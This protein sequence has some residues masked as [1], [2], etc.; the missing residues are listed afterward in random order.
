MQTAFADDGTWV[1]RE[2]VGTGV[3]NWADWS[4][5][6]NWEGG[7][8]PD[9]T[10]VI[11]AELPASQVYIRATQDVALVNFKSAGTK[12]EDYPVVLSDKTIAIR[13]AA[14]TTVLLSGLHFYAPY[15]WTTTSV[16]I[17]PNNISLCGDLAAKSGAL[18]FG[19]RVDFRLDRYANSSSP[20]RTNE[21][22]PS[23]QDMRMEGSAKL[24]FYCPRGS[25]EDETSRWSQAAGSPFLTRAAGQDE[26]SLSVGTI[27]TGEGVPED[28][29]LKRILPDGSIE[30]SAAVTET[31]ED[32]ELT[33]AAFAP[34]VTYAMNRLGAYNGAGV[35]ELYV[36][37][38]RAEDEFTVNLGLLQ[39]VSGTV[40]NCGRMKI[41]TDAGFLPG[42]IVFH[43]N[44]DSE[45]WYYLVS[46]C[47]LQIN[48]TSTASGCKGCR[49]FVDDATTTARISVAAGVSA[50]SG[51]LCSLAGTLVKDDDGEL[52]VGFTNVYTGAMVVEAG[53][54]TPKIL[55]AGEAGHLSSLTV[56]AN[57]TFTVPTEGFLCDTPA[58][59]AG[60]R[61]R[62]P[63]V[64]FCGDVSDAAF[65][66]VDV[67]DC[68]LCD[69]NTGA[70][71]VRGGTYAP[72]SADGQPI[73]Y[74]SLL[75]KAG[76]T[77]VVPAEG[78]SCAVLTLEPGATLVGPGVLLYES[79][80]EED[81]SEVSIGC[82]G[83]RN[84]NG[85]GTDALSLS[86]VSGDSSIWAEDGDTIL[87]FRTNA[88]VKVAG[89]GVVDVLL[90][91]GGGGGGAYGGGGGGGGGVVY[92]QRFEVVDGYYGVTVGR[93]GLGSTASNKPGE[94]GFDSSC[95]GLVAFGGGGGGTVSA[96][97]DGGCGGGAGAKG[98]VTAGTL[99]G[100][101]G[102]EGQGFAGGAS[103]T[104]STSHW[105]SLGGGGGGAGTP[106]QTA[107][108]EENPG[109][110][111]NGGDGI[112][113]TICKTETY[114]GGGGG[115][116]GLSGSGYVSRG[117]AGGG[118]AG[119]GNSS[120]KTQVGL[121]GTDGLG[122]GGGGGGRYVQNWSAGGN[123]GSGIVIIRFRREIDEKLLPLKPIAEGGQIRRRKGYAFHTFST[124]GFFTV[125]QDVYVDVLAVGGG[126]GG[127]T[128]AGG[129]GGGGGVTVVSNLLLRAGTY[130]VEVGLGGKGATNR[131]F[132]AKDGGLS[133]LFTGATNY[134][135]VA[136]GGGGGGS[137]GFAGGTGANGGGAGGAYPYHGA[138]WRDG[139]KALSDEGFGG[140]ASTNCAS[141]TYGW[142]WCFGG[143]GGG[144]GAVGVT[145]EFEVNEATSTLAWKIPGDGG[146]GVC[147]DFTG[148]STWY[149]GGGGGAGN[150]GM[151][152]TSQDFSKGG[153]GGGGIGR[154]TYAGYCFPG[155]D[156]EDGLGGGG[157]G[158]SGLGDAF[159][160]SGASTDKG[161]GKGGGNGGSGLLVIRYPLGK[162][163]MLML[164][165]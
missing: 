93:G 53:T 160:G 78:V 95:F 76:A 30:L 42:K 120:T 164:V 20:V 80:N 32:N 5:P 48:T 13:D 25:A 61:L 126:G 2:G 143:G 87:I 24:H 147:L 148:I 47:H 101:S 157:G 156:G 98:Y 90:V 34:Q 72:T 130:P 27:V 91:A 7:V 73:L 135:V 125:P 136:M 8:I 26:V 77:L 121:P 110:P 128:Y 74:P 54:L 21:A 103:S 45:Q 37:K 12:F 133:M 119:G 150:V 81:F 165:R 86:V 127:G 23:S 134:S 58:F 9:G 70:V 41:G 4:D 63:G 107:N 131:T 123:G 50:D 106:G 138:S 68:A 117:G 92:T 83:L 79:A 113:C 1:Q 161:Y 62:G 163:G 3:T 85:S 17:G 71:A 152:S 154:A 57:A 6:E 69:T 18:M 109:K 67:Q 137:M 28:T 118:G 122:G 129:G 19:G 84:A 75:V 141:A 140:G 155:T 10:T 115:G 65:A 162:T 159:A 55:T 105:N 144:A 14:G 142:N 49:L 158:G 15:S 124:N 60:A 153:K 88:T 66:A 100:G 146:D 149:G 64:F 31:S 116:N 46:D 151:E 33:F 36:N 82:G 35:R 44:D 108:G 43:T 114:G 145:A 102:T 89:G 16:Y 51:A 22:W 38:S 94:N 11:K 56:K 104:S 97:L 111:G 39:R 132:S 40:Q 96:G 99:D 112:V 29:F 139:G 59:E 52:V